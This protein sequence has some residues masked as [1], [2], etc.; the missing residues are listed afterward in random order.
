M[1]EALILMNF[2][3]TREKQAN[4]VPKQKMGKKEREIMYMYEV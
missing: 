1:R 3:E 4:Y 2:Q